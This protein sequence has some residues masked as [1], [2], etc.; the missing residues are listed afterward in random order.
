MM[1]DEIYRGIGATDRPDVEEPDDM[2]DDMRSDARDMATR[3]TRGGT[4]PRRDELARDV[5]RHSVHRQSI[6]GDPRDYDDVDEDDSAMMSRGKMGMGRK[7]GMKPKG[8][9]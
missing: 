6:T 8:G 9:Y 2:G 7:D 3:M 1:Q 4:Q 5:D